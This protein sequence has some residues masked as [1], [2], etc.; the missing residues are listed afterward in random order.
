[1]VAACD[2]ARSHGVRPGLTL[3]EATALCSG[4][5]HADHEPD[6]DARG[7]VALGRWMMR[8]TPAVAVAQPAGLFLDVTGCDRLFG[9]FDALLRRATDAVAG[10]GLSAHLAIAPTAGAAWALAHTGRTITED[11]VVPALAPLSPGRLRID[12]AVTDTLRTVGIDT[13]AQLMALPRHLLPAR[14]GAEVL[15]RLDQATG[16]AAEPLVLLPPPAPVAAAMGFDGAVHS[17]EAIWAVLHELLAR[18][19]VDLRRRGGGALVVRAT[20]WCEGEDPIVRDVPLSRPARD[21]GSLFNLMR[22]ATEDVRARDGFTAV[23]MS[24]PRW[25]RL[26]ETQARLIGRDRRD[27]EAEIARLAER[28]RVRWSH[29]GVLTARAVESHLP[30]R[31]WAKGLFSDGP[32]GRAGHVDRHAKARPSGPSLNGHAVPLRLLPTPTEV[33]ATVRPS[34]DDNGRPAMFVADGVRHELAHAAG[35]RRVAGTW[36][37]GHD[38]TRD[39]YDVVTPDGRRF[40]VFRALPSKRWFLHGTFG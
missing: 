10:L 34:E 31:A 16:R 23:E 3:A 2:A 9:G 13:I 30:E 22:C 26:A 8:F 33:Y 4:L 20:F 40:W 15:T 37:T 12:P 1:V 38:K 24:V 39:Y 14:F 11:E 27:A 7:L 19:A 25:E 21:V 28:L 5:T 32:E 17:L 29:Q 18:V 6:R 36:W 35:P